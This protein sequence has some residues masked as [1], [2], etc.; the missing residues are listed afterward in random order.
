RARTK[1]SP[2]ARCAPCS[3]A[4]RYP[5]RS[6][7][8]SPTASRSTDTILN[9]STGSVSARVV[10]TQRH[11]G[12][13]TQL[14]DFKPCLCASVSLCLISA[15]DPP[16]PPPPPSFVSVCG[17]GAGVSLCPHRG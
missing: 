17:G 7:S 9:N 2:A 4:R 16:P 13:E 3:S 14:N 1:S 15:A 11:G 5:T 10:L 6:P 12:T 8:S